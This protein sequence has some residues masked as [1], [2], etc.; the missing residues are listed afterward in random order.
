[1]ALLRTCIGTFEG[2]LDR[3]GLLVS[4]GSAA[5]AYAAMGEWRQAAIAIGGGGQFE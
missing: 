4:T 5:L 2:L 1:M 3:W